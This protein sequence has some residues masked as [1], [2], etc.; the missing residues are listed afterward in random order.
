M[1]TTS[2]KYEFAFGKFSKDLIH[3]SY[4]CRLRFVLMCK[5]IANNVNTNVKLC[6]TF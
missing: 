1:G 3:S 5:I 6:S 4:L 2:D